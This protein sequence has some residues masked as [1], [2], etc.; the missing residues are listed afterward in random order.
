MR[1][2]SI[3][4]VG[5]DGDGPALIAQLIEDPNRF[6]PNGIASFVR[7][8][9]G[10]KALAVGDEVVV[11]LPGPW[12]GPVRVERADEALL[13][14][15]LDGHMEAGHIRFDTV[16]IEGGYRFRVRSWARAGDRAFLL[17]HLLTKVAWEAQTAMWV[18]MCLRAGE[19]SGGR[20]VG[21][22]VVHAE[23]LDEV[24]RSAGTP[25]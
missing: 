23:V 18:Q 6:C 9:R 1:T 5:P 20:R 8:D 19:I 4:I 15:T 12:D 14:Q 16:P 25:A 11:E 24:A 7:D 10:V 17:L 13:L 2:F 22:L 3:D 21:Q